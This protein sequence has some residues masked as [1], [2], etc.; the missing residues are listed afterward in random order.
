MSDLSPPPSRSSQEARRRFLR[1]FLLG[2]AVVGAALAG[3][4][5]VSRG[6]SVKLRPPGAI[7]ESAFLAAC[8][9]CGQCVQVC[10]VKAIV[11]GDVDQGFGLG[12]P[13]IDARNQACDFSCDA[14]QCILACPTGALEPIAPSE[15][16]KEMWAK[17]RMGVAR[18]DKPT[19]CLAFQEKGVQG[20]ARGA[21]YKGLHR[22]VDK[23]RWKP[24]PVAEHIYDLA[25]CD[26]CVRECPIEGAISMLPITSHTADQ[27]RLPQITGECVGCGMCEMICP[28]E[29]AV[30]VID[31]RTTGR[32]V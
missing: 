18:V 11:L 13:H 28:V 7:D 15:K 2:G 31:I 4:L 25:S 19:Q 12:V 32:V 3:W 6:A 17:V 5:P 30:I 9:K 14:L 23:D 21:P 26:L 1:S 10:P 16:V 24:F 22:Y 20:P 8:I 27:R 29:P